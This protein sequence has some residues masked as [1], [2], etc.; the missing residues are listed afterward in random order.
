MAAIDMHLG[1]WKPLRHG[2]LSL[3]PGRPAPAPAWHLAPGRVSM[4]VGLEWMVLVY[5]TS[6]KEH[7][8][9]NGEL[10]SLSAALSLIPGNKK[11]ATN[12]EV[13]ESPEW[14]SLTVSVREEPLQVRWYTQV[15]TGWA[16]HS[17]LKGLLVGLVERHEFC[18]GISTSEPQPVRHAVMGEN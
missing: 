9:R 3:L 13:G 1:N 12:Q 17:L 18:I 10:M 5:H 8:S 2:L 11:G 6:L 14:D 16:K 7:L 4:H 15:N